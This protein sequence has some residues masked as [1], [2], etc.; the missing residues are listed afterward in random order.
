MVP[1][2]RQLATAYDAGIPI[3]RA[4]D[5]VAANAKDP[6][7][8]KVL[9]EINERLKQGST[10]GDAAREHH[11]HL[12]QFFI[13]LLASGEHGG[14]LDVMLRDLSEY[15]EDRVAMNREIRGA[16]VYPI[17]MV[18]ASWFLGVFALMIVS[19]LSFEKPFDFVTF[20]GEYLAFQGK[21]LGVLA[22]VFVA[23]IALSRFGIPQWAWG[24]FST[25]IW[26]L[27][28]VVRKFALARFFR[29]MSLLITSGL[30][31]KRCI[32]SAAE[33]TANPY[34]RRDLLLALP[35]VSEGATLT[36][37]FT[38][39]KTLTPIAREMLF[40]GEQ[41]GNLDGCLR[42][43]SEYHFE[44]AKHAVSVA[45]RVMKLVMMLAVGALVGYVVISFYTRL[46]SMYDSF[47]N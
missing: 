47:L 29:S 34:I 21:A 5:I 41:T 42:K 40:V 17:F 30:D 37:A 32:S 15:Y 38:A 2:C 26:P 14:K 35:A 33:V 25:N 3:I 36:Q 28:N 12:P 19:R 6:S 16:M 45:L 18:C 13:E 22:L 23:C 11:K 9:G 46:F 8:R 24:W 4:I 20:L 31:I 44:E 39:A 43:V 1:L 10:L 27:K 7:A